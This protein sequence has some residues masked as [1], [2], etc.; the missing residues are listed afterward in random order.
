MAIPALL[1]AG[2]E[3]YRR[4]KGTRTDTGTATGEPG[5]LYGF[6]MKMIDG[7]P[8]P[9]SEYRGQVLLIVNTASLCGFTPQ[10]DTLEALHKKYRD[11]GLRVLGFPANEFG[12][13]EP[14][15]D[16]QIA[17]FCRTRFS[18]SFDLFSKITVKG[19]GIHPLYKFLTTES[20]YNGDIAWN[21]SKFLVDRSGRVSARFGPETDPM[22]SK[23]TGAVERLLN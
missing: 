15:P 20:G 14:G 1:F 21:F 8:R 16:E 19:P 10:Y 18:I 2:Y 4:F 7:K 22:S 3:A 12:A 6:E 13:Q 23:L 17:A 11:R 5:K 9:L